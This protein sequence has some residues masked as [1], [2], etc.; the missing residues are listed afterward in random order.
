VVPY[1]RAACH[2]CGGGQMCGPLTLIKTNKP[3]RFVDVFIVKYL[4]KWSHSTECPSTSQCS[5]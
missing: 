2:M 1:A 3:G 5:S 4:R